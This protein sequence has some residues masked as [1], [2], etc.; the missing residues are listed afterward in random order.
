[1]VGSPVSNDDLQLFILHRLNV[2]Y[3]FLIVSLNSKPS[4]L[5]FNE[6]ASLLLAH[7]QGVQK[8]ALTTTA[9]PFPVSI[10]NSL[11]P[12]QNMSQTNLASTNPSSATTEVDLLSQF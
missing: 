3:D 10:P 7:E 11:T 9:M 2:E 5:P 6:L 12:V 1:M 4:A 8:N